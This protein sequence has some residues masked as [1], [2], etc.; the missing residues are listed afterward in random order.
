M[1]KYPTRRA[2]LK[3]REEDATR[4]E[5]DAQEKRLQHQGE[6]RELKESLANVLS[7][8]EKDKEENKKQMDDMRE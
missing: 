1:E 8:R 4:A 7:A 6:V 2:L 3:Q 5:L